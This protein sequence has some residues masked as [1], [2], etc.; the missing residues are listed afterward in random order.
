M[1]STYPPPPQRDV[2]RVWIDETG[3]RGSSA[4]ASPFFGFAAVVVRGSNMPLLSGTKKALNRDLGR[5]ESIELHWSK[6][7]K[8]HDK[9][10]AAC[11][12]LSQCPV[13]LIYALIDKTS[14]T[15]GLRHQERL[16]NWPLRLV[17]ER[18]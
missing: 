11:E 14:L 1:S 13:R 3:D 4:S 12:A 15:P 2:F 10:Y 9:R 7:L 6:N 16:Y 8:G 5:S 17:L 18:V